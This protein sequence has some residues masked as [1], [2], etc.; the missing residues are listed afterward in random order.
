MSFNIRTLFS[1]KVLLSGF[2]LCSLGL[3]ALSL[4]AQAGEKSCQDGYFS[5]DPAPIVNQTQTW[6]SIGT[7]DIKTL[8]MINKPPLEKNSVSKFLEYYHDVRF[9]PDPILFDFTG[10]VTQYGDNRHTPNL[11]IKITNDEEYKKYVARLRKKTGAGQRFKNGMKTFGTSLVS[12]PYSL[13]ILIGSIK[14]FGIA[15]PLMVAPLIVQGLWTDGW[16]RK[17]ILNR[18][19]ELLRC[20]EP[21]QAAADIL[22]RLQ[23]V[24]VL[25]QDYSD[26]LKNKRLST[27][28]VLPWIPSIESDG[29]K[30]YSS[31]G[32]LRFELPLKKAI[33]LQ[34]FE[35]LVAKEF[36]R[37]PKNTF[38]AFPK[39]GTYPTN[40]PMPSLLGQDYITTCTLIINKNF[41]SFDLVCYGDK[42][43]N[44]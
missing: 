20:L 12:V 17:Y 10:H 30:S 29:Q 33:P 43:R 23:K 14:S 19:T 6:D 1:S 39:K 4:T 5:L 38:Y 32:I 21:P 25:Q 31:D 8:P 2:L 44:E 22:P 27:Y 13:N 28:H 7:I 34:A 36:T 42:H 37:S 15:A 40:L 41:N 35:E 26:F 16:E 18:N 11:S 24:N 9:T 3:Q